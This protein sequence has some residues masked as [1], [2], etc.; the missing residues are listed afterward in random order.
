MNYL[1]VAS[2]P[3]WFDRLYVIGEIVPNSVIDLRTVNRLIFS[4]HLARIDETT[5][6]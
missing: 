5:L 4:R 2:K 3:V 6:P 1:Y